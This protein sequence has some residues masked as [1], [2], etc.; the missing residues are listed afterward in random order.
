MVGYDECIVGV[1][2]KNGVSPSLCYDK[3]K[4]LKKLMKDG[5]SEEDAIEFFEYN[6]LGANLGESTPHVL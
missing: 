6:Q 4:I 5:M 3:S 2:E 1:V